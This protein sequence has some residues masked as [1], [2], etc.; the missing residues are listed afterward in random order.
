LTPEIVRALQGEFSVVPGPEHSS[1]GDVARQTLN[2]LVQDSEN[3]EVIARLSKGTA[4]SS[5]EGTYE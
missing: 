4:Q 3:L 5:K 2:V 1:K